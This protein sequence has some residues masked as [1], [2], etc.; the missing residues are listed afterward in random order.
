MT[1]TPLDFSEQQQQ[2]LSSELPQ[3]KYEPGR[4][5]LSIPLPADGTERLTMIA[6]VATVLLAV[7]RQ[8]A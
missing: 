1:V 2:A 3:A 8:T 6:S 4:A 7:S 5:Q